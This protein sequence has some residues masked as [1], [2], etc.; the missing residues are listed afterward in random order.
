MRFP[1]RPAVFFAFTIFILAAHSAWAASDDACQLVTQAQVSAAV[2]V[3]VGAGTH[4]T[5]TF[6]KTCTWTA[7]GNNKDVSNV[8]ISFQPAQSF[9]G[10][11]SMTEMM[12]ANAKPDKQG[13]RA[14]NDVASGIGDD[15][16]YTTM[17]EGYSALLVK[18]GNVALKIAI[19]GAM[20]EQKKKDAEKKLALEALAKS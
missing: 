6:L 13:N 16:F 12:V 14:H 20:P 17:G 5:P 18:K 8:T 10:T 2:G 15:A 9:N 4:V 7:S 19:Y 11:K 1:S 3:P